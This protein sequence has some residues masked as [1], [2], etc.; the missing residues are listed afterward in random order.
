MTITDHREVEHVGLIRLDHRKLLIMGYL[1][2]CEA[3]AVRPA[4]G[5]KGVIR[6]CRH[7]CM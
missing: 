4:S 1:L 6:D 3:F 7:S 5:R 2:R